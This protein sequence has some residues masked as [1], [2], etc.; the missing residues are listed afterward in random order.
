LWLLL[1]L[2][3]AVAYAPGVGNDYVVWDDD[4]YI[5]DN[6]FLGSVGGLLRIWTP[7]DPARKY[8]P[9]TYTFHWVEYQLWG[10]RSTGY[11]IV[12]VALHALNA[13]LAFALLR[14]FGASNGVALLAAGLFAAHPMQAASVAWLAARKTV[15]ST[16]LAL[17]GCLAYWRYRRMGQVRWSRLAFV[18]FG[19]ALLSK[20]AAITFICSVVLADW[21]LL[22]RRLWDAVVPFLPLLI[23]IGGGLIY[24]DSQFEK[25]A[26]AT[27]AE[28]LPL[29]PL[30]ASAAF[31]F[32]TGK[33]LWPAGLALIYPKWTV[34]LSLIWVL[35]LVCLGVTAAVVWLL[36]RRIGVLAVWG[37]AH[38]FVTLLP[39][40]GLLSFGYLKHSPVGDQYV[41]P[42]ALGF[43]LLVGLAVERFAQWIGRRKA[44]LVVA[45]VGVAAVVG[46]GWLTGTRVP[47]WRG[48]LEFWSNTIDQYPE[49]RFG[50]RRLA[51][52]YEAGGQLSEAV[53][54]YTWLLRDDPND[55]QVHN[56]LGAVLDTLGKPAEAL[57]HYRAAAER[58]AE[59]DL[60]EVQPNLAACLRKLGLLSAEIARLRAAL[61]REPN[62]A[63][64]RYAL[65]TALAADGLITEAIQH[66]RQLIRDHPNDPHLLYR[67]AFLL[68]ELRQDAA[69]AETYLLAAR[70]A[71]AQ[72]LAQLWYK[73]NRELA[74]LPDV[75]AG[76]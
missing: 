63:E 11:Y 25:S 2:V 45:P 70:Q 19:A 41:Y 56:N 6:P 24:I 46:L 50:R 20:T 38:F 3:V 34:T 21:L 28:P 72:N 47:Q 69:A 36:R 14:A 29:R 5:R 54:Q 32:Y 13:V 26:G 7:I 71:R 76:D 37:A 35:P 30:A 31:W 40:L 43:F 18:L 16:T 75:A 61:A 53:R 4:I 58:A 8:Y 57:E 39:I 51:D 48:S 44:R 42:A 9:I 66:A 55:A 73:I 67:I 1:P 33:L 60:A 64:T 74:G 65:A 52:A 49:F 15:L 27:Y 12:N 68:R 10:K 22:R 17:L 59:N 23:V 62:D